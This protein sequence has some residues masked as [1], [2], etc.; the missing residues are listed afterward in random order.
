MPNP[1]R[2]MISRLFTPIIDKT[3]REQLAVA[4][5]DNTFFIGTRRYDESD[6]DRLEYD[7]AD[8]LDQ[9]LEAWRESPLARRIVE[10]TSQYVV[11][12]GFDIQCE[13]ETTRTFISQFWHHR[14]NRMPSRVIEMCDEL[15][16]TGNLFLLIS[17][18]QAGMSYI[19]AIPAADIDLITPSVNDIE[20]PVSFTTKADENLQVYSYPAYHQGTD[21]QNPDGSFPSVVL[22]YAINR[23]AGAQWGEPDLAPLLRWLR[24]YSAWLEDRVRLNRFRNAFLYVVTSHFGSEEARRAR[25]TQLAIKKLIASGVGLPLHF[26]AEPEG[27]NRTTAESAGGPTFRRFEQRQQ[28]F[29]WLLSDLLR[30]VLSRRAMVDRTVNPDVGIEISGADISA[31][32]NVAHAIASVNILNALERLRD[33]GLISDREVLRLTYRFAGEAGD[34]DTLLAGGSGVDMR[35]ITKPIQPVTKD[36]VNINTGATKSNIL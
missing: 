6:R 17:T 13:D 12:P 30:V 11:G 3:V 28:F 15:T 31:R 10:L 18:D 33:M 22:H 14:L 34:L 5:N 9:C 16:R 4:E 19:R 32:D 21:A 36:P 25:Q 26:L 23:P 27:S 35:G 8:I 29:T 2:T 1:L 20:Q 7:R 24:R